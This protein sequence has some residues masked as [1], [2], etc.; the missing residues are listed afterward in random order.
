M[1]ALIYLLLAGSML[2]TAI[3]AVLS[4][5]V[6]KVAGNQNPAQPTIAHHALMPVCV[7]RLATGC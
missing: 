5:L 7:M 1:H 6:I 2:D 3:R 4:T